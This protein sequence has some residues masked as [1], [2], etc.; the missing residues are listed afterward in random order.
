MYWECLMKNMLDNRNGLICL[1]ILNAVAMFYLCGMPKAY[2]NKHHFFEFEIQPH[3]VTTEAYMS[4]QA[5]IIKD[6]NGKA[7]SI[8]A[9]STLLKH[10]YSKEYKD[11]VN[12]INAALGENND[13]MKDYVTFN[14]EGSDIKLYMR[15]SELNDK[16]KFEDITERY[17]AERKAYR[18]NKR[19]EAEKTYSEYMLHQRLWFCFPAEHISGLI[20]GFFGMLVSLCFGVFLLLIMKNECLAKSIILLVLISF[21]IFAIICFPPILWTCR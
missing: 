17:Q 12:K 9:G 8:S 5:M 13:D 20:S 16:E 3:G 21:K 19:K 7:I 11:T 15:P 10:T 1:V 4:R 14:S 2:T 18:E 6:T